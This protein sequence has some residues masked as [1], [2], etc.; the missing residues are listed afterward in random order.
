MWPQTPSLAD[1]PVS[2]FQ[3]LGLHHKTMPISV[4]L[5]LSPRALQVLEKPSSPERHPASARPVTEMISQEA[6]G[7][8]S[9]TAHSAGFL[10]GPVEE[11]THDELIPLA[12]WV[13]LLG[14]ACHIISPF[15]F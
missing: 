9:Q 11:L 6:A 5:G 3:V 15:L 4:V 8:V 13:F 1:S 12:I 2:A 14:T 10:A 7:A